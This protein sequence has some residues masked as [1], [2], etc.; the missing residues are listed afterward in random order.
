MKESG[1]GMTLTLWV[2]WHLGSSTQRHFNCKDTPVLGTAANV[3]SLR[4]IRSKGRNNIPLPQIPFTY[5]HSQ[6]LGDT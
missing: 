6:K 4:G 5:L 3:T 1:W 2:L